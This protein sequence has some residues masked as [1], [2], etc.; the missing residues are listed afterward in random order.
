MRKMSSPFLR[1]V[2]A[3]LATCLSLI[4]SFNFSHLIS[5]WAL[6]VPAVLGYLLVRFACLLI[7]FV[8]LSS[9]V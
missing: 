8:V 1:R 3:L 4:S 5:L 2:K 7:G 6:L 9:L